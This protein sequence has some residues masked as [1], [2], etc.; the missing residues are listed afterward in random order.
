MHTPP[1]MHRLAEVLPGTWRL[2]ATNIV[3]WIDGRH[4]ETRYSY[5][6]VTET[7]FVL[8]ETLAYT[9]QDGRQR[10]LQGRARRVRDEFVWRGA[11]M[12]VSIVRRWNIIGLSDDGAV[13]VMRNRK[14]PFFPDGMSILV[15]EGVVVEELRAEVAKHATAWGLEPEDFATLTWL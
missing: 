8:H 3:F 4:D 14:A 6:I 15:R 1:T 2:G 13:A 12:R 11:G 10:Q 5:E 9:T 7:P